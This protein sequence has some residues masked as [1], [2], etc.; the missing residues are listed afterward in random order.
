[1]SSI[2]TP[3]VA[4]ASKITPVQFAVALALREQADIADRERDRALLAEVVTTANSIASRF[5]VKSDW[6]KVDR[7]RWTNI[8]LGLEDLTRP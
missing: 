2:E 3:P 4:P 5:W 6:S 7:T 8:A 1:M